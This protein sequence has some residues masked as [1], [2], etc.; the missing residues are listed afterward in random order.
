[1]AC[2]CAHA[3]GRVRVGVLISSLQEDNMRDRIVSSF[4]FKKFLRDH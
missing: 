1:M 2:A 4:P 3:C